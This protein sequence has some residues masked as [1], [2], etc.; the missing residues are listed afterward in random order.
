MVEVGIGPDDHS[1]STTLLHA[2]KSI[3]SVKEDT[4]PDQVFVNRE[5]V[6]HI[7]KGLYAWD[8]KGKNPVRLTIKYI[9]S[10]G[11]IQIHVAGE[12]PFSNF[13][14]ELEP[15]AHFNPIVSPEPL[16]PTEP[17]EKSE[18]KIQEKNLPMKNQKLY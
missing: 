11:N 9:R 6:Y 1:L 13:K 15:V 10:F 8:A 18:K 14:E 16:P 4:E 17:I 5:R 2:L 3:P 7:K 12:E